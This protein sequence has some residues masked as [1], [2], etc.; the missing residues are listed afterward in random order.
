MSR[1]GDEETHALNLLDVVESEDADKGVRVVGLAL[2]DFSHDGRGIGGSEHRKLPHGPVAAIIVARKARVF[3]GGVAGLVELNARDETV[4]D[5]VV[6]LGFHVRAGE[7][8]KEGH[9]L[10]LNVVLRVD[11]FLAVSLGNG[12]A[13]SRSRGHGAGERPG[14]GGGWGNSLEVVRTGVGHGDQS[15][16]EDGINSNAEQQKMTR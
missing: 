12:G 2:V 6:D 8:V 9:S 15:N 13:E 14:H 11:D 3:P 5:H 10:V 4:L 16:E 7:R 1:S